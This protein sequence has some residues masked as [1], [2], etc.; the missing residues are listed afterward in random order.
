MKNLVII[1]AGKLGREVLGWAEQAI[2]Q[3]AQWRIKGFLDSRADALAGFDYSTKI[4]GAVESY[5]VAEND[6]FI[7]AIGDP[8]DKV[9]YYTQ[10]VERGG[11]FVNLIHPLAHVGTNV[12]LGVG[13]VMAPF[14]CTTSDLKIGN[15][16][17]VLPFSNL[18]H[19]T[20]V[21]DWSQI[22][23]HCGVN[24]KVTLDE[25]VFLGSHACIV[26][27]KRIGAW[28]FV[29]AGAVVANDVPAGARVY[30][31]P[32]RNIIS[33]RGSNEAVL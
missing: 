2:A 10:I 22:S 12:Q 11:H 20:V 8:K 13:V 28:A 14:T 24:G 27:G 1:S 29:A 4:L 3:G 23:S 9:K 17:T 7:G 5:Q 6:V 33:N 25:G 30:G 18:T 19:D 32:G 15:H 31:N 26:P 21:G 16:V